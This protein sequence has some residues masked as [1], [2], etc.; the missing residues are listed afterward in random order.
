MACWN[1]LRDWKSDFPDDF[2]KNWFNAGSGV[3]RTELFES[4]GT[5]CN[6]AV[7]DNGLSRRNT[8]A[9]SNSVQGATTCPLLK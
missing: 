3:D 5:S 6:S 1:V 8:K 7:R 2:A 4:V 9:F